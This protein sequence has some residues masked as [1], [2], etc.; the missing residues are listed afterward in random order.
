MMTPTHLL[1]AGAVL[2]RRH[3]P[4]EN[5]AVLAGAL[6]P[7]LSIYVLYGW[8]KLIAGISSRTVWSQLYWQE[9]W[10]TLSAISNSLPLYAALLLAAWTIGLRWLILLAAAALIH[11]AFDLPF[12]ASDA[13]MHFWPI[14]DIRI[15]SPLSYWDS[16]HYGDIVRF[17]ELAL[18]LVSLTIIWR[19]FDALWVKAAMAVLLAS[20][21][22][23]PLYFRL[24]LG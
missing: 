23:V 5:A 7:D 21:V 9:P 24:T 1:I 11:L 19:R 2:T 22:A 10:Q 4:A 6:I 17:G 16:R 12:H 13:H 3:R 8:S 20:Y 14:S 18:A 15:V